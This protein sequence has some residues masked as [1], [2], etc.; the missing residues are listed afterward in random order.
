[1][2]QK[3]VSTEGG[4]RKSAKGKKSNPIS[5]SSKTGKKASKNKGGQ[6]IYDETGTAKGPKRAK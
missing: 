4:K 5:V 3:S 2:A 1:M 6:F